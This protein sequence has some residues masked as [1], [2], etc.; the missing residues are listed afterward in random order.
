MMNTGQQS[1]PDS[2]FIAQF[3]VSRSVRQIMTTSIHVI[4][5][6]LI[7]F[8]VSNNYAKVAGNLT[9]YLQNVDIFRNFAAVT[10]E[11]AIRA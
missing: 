9:L 5:T 11:R 6:I 2:I 8:Y 1:T 7:T 4:R 3:D 10:K